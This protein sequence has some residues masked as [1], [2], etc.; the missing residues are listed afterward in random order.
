MAVWQAVGYSLLTGRDLRTDTETSSPIAPV[1]G[2]PPALAWDITIFFGKATCDS[3]F[4]ES[5]HEAF[6]TDELANLWNEDAP[7][8]G[9][10]ENSGSWVIVGRAEAMAGLRRGAPEADNPYLDEPSPA[11]GV[12]FRTAVSAQ[13]G[14]TNPPDHDPDMVIDRRPMAS[15]WSR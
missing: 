9:G 10:E 1:S 14:V 5:A 13:F 4:W 12:R 15:M 3:H 8:H 6:S 11:P 7:E 2:I